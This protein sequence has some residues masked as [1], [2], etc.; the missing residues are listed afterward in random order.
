MGEGSSTYYDHCDFYIDGTRELYAG[1]NLSGSGWLHY[2]YNVTA[3]EHTFTWSYSKDSSVNSE[4]DY[5]A[6]DNV[7]MQAGEI[8]WNTPVAVENTEYTFSGLTPETN[9]CVR[10][11]GVCNDVESAWSELI[12]FSTGEGNTDTQTVALVEGW[13][14]WTP[15]VEI[16]L[17]D[18][19]AALGT[20]GLIIKSQDISAVYVASTNT[21]RNNDLEIE[22]G[23]MYKIKTSVACT[24][25]LS[26]IVVDPAEHPITVNTGV[27]WVGFI[28]TE[29]TSLDQAFT[30]FTPANLD[31]VKTAHG[32]AVYYRN[33]GWRGT[34]STLSPGQGYLYKS[35]ASGKRTFT[36]PS[37]E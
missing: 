18:L 33:K 15:T 23:K 25:T 10:V 6:V 21:W 34:V 16:T 3:G 32:T 13:N 36:C 12:L 35:K 28:G 26:G 20:N 27:N 31:V 22:V 2:I 37:A 14:W 29:V 19:E 24:I 5:F 30:E 7:L 11:Q 1:A 17:A 8:T 9:Y 4:G